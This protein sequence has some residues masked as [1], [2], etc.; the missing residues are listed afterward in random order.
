LIISEK[1]LGF[2]G[3]HAALHIVIKLD[4]WSTCTCKLEIWILELWSTCTCELEQSM[5]AARKA[6]QHLDKE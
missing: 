4:R 3:Y 5:D 2:S 1:N 6:A